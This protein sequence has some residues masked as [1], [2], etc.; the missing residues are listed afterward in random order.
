M[1][2]LLLFFVFCLFALSFEKKSYYNGQFLYFLTFYRPDYLLIEKN[3]LLG[4]FNNE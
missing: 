1:E 3:E 2:H 4:T